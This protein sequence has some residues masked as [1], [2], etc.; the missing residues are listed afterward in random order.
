MT[1]KIL[2]SI[3]AMSLCNF[4]V[5]AQTFTLKG[6]LAQNTL[7]VNPYIYLRYELRGET[8]VDSCR[9]QQ[10]DYYFSGN[11]EY[12]AEATLSLKVSEEKEAYYKQTRLLKPYE[13]TFFLD[14]GNMVAISA[15][16]LWDTRITGGAAETDRQAMKAAWRKIYERDEKVLKPKRDAAYSAKDSVLIAEVSRLSAKSDAEQEAVK[17]QFMQQ[18]P[19]TGIMLKLLKEYTRTKIDP[20]VIGPLYDGMLPS[21]KTSPEGVAFGKRLAKAREI[22]P[23]QPAP[24][25]VLKDRNDST[26]TL[27]SLKGKVV[28]LDFWGSWCYPC[29]MSHPH[30]RALYARYKDAGFEILGVSNERGEPATWKEKWTQAMDKDQMT[31]PN[32]LNAVAS[33]EK[34]KGILNAYDVQAYPTKILIDREGKIVAKLVGNSESSNEALDTHLERLLGAGH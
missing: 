32:V 25:V 12:P 9:L 8:I 34:D 28:L 27:A 11:V 10:G 14:A 16:E 2:F 3:T 15:K 7:A 13:H 26:I 31:W 19:R 22:S 5:Q 23:G 29:R 17:L 24:P 6:K 20:A 1:K 21:L 4:F 30:L 33:T 18:H